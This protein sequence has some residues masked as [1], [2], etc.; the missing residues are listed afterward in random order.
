LAAATSR[1]ISARRAAANRLFTTSIKAARSSID[2]VSTEA[3][4]RAKGEAVFSVAVTLD[5]ATARKHNG[6]MTEMFQC[7]VD[8]EVLQRAHQISEQMGM[9]TAEL[10]RVFLKML[11]K[12]GQ[13]PFTP[14]GESEEDEMLGPIERR[15]EM[16][17]YFHE[18]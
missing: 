2:N 3:S 8:K 18:R 11:A 17:D 1:T 13:L 9:S 7:R 15:R 4:A 10:V 5:L 6:D 12:R 14:E 16:L